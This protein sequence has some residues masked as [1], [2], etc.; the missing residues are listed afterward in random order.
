MESQSVVFNKKPV[1]DRDFMKWASGV[2]KWKSIALC[3]LIY[4]ATI[5]LAYIGGEWSGWWL[6]PISVIIIG[7]LQN[8][9][10]ILFHEGA[11]WLMH[12]NKTQNDFWT[13]FFCGV[14]LLQ[15][16]RNYRLFHWTHHRSTGVPGIDPEIEIYKGQ[17][18]HYERRSTAQTL[19]MFF[20]DL[21]GINL[22]K[23]QISLYKYLFRMV[24]E[25]KHVISTPRDLGVYILFWGPVLFAC[26]K[27]NLWIEL[28]VFWFLPIVTVTFFFLKLHAYGEHTGLDGPT[29]FERTWFHNFNPVTNF[30]IYPIYS[31]FHVE[32]HI[33]PTVPWYNM[34]KFR[35][36]LMENDYYVKQSEKV[37]A[38]GFF[39]GDTTIYNSMICGKGLYTED[40]KFKTAYDARLKDLAQFTSSKNQDAE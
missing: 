11:H 34:K 3:F 17:G 35:K 31:G 21:V 10:L 14:P 13:D 18:F 1:V 8:H 30:F 33:Y 12:P 6:A 2:S 38:N 16:V 29:E 36:K 15:V 25:Q 24:K 26:W 22:L 23:F 37:T 32:H 20:L 39:F 7:G 28:L 5:G 40:T 19:K 4:V 9:L 27:W